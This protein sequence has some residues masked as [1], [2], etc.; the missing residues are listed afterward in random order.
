MTTWYDKRVVRRSVIDTT[1]VPSDGNDDD[2]NVIL[3]GIVADG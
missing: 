1:L 3:G 2:R